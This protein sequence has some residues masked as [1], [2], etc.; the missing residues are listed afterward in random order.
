[1]NMGDTVVQVDSPAFRP[2]GTMQLLSIQENETEQVTPA[3][4]TLQHNR[5]VSQ[6]PPSLSMQNK[7]KFKMEN[8]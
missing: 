8:R 4:Q 1:M 7:G 2:Q 3:N 5:S 6:Q